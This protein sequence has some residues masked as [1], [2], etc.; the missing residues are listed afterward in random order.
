MSTQRDYLPRTDGGLL[1]FSSNF[2]TKLSAEPEAFGQ[3]I[4]VATLLAT[5]QS[6]FA[7][8]LTAAVDPTTRGSHTRLLKNEARLDLV[9]YLRQ[10][11]QAITRT[12]TV[13]DAQRDALGLPI[14]DREP[15]PRHA[16]ALAPLIEVM[17]VIGTLVK[18]RLRDAQAPD[19]R[20]KPPS[21]EGATV[22]S[23]CGE[24]P[25]PAND[26]GW[27]WEGQTSRTITEVQFPATVPSQKVWVTAVWY[28]E[29]GRIS[30]ATVPVATV[31]QAQPTQ[32][33]A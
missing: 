12:L 24:T 16:P 9:A 23:Y 8:R 31:L 33:A 30:P 29:R 26:P 20:A 28:T 7:T 25:P 17:S 11:A 13:T 4:A 15:S 19:S 6:L 1:S 21:A 3:T 14:V 5:K 2:S 18:L 10:V 32:Q 27:R 22:F